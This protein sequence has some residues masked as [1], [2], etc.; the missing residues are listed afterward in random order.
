MKR[1]TDEELLEAVENAAAIGTRGADY[2]SQ[3]GREAQLKA[4]VLQT[5]YAERQTLAAQQTAKATQRYTRYMAWSVFGILLSAVATLVLAVI[6][7]CGG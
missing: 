4:L 5:R 7:S 2:N 1:R 6:Q 3:V